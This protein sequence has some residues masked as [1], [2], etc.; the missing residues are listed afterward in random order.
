MYS[1]LIDTVV[2][3]TQPYPVFLILY[4]RKDRCAAICLNAFLIIGIVV[5]NII[6]DQTVLIIEHVYTTGSHPEVIVF[7]HK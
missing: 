3:G 6:N 5:F 7:V 4:N 1:S 2:F